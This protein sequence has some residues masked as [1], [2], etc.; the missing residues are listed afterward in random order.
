MEII[1]PTNCPSCSTELI[2]QNTQ[3]YCPNDECPAKN[4]KKVLNFAK[5]LKIKGLGPATQEKLSLTCIS[6]I[7]TIEESEVKSVLGEVLGSKL[8][9]QIEKSKSASLNELLPALGIPLIGDSA[10][11]KLCEAI[12]HFN[13]VNEET[14]KKAGLG[15]KAT[16]NLI[17][18]K[19]NFPWEELPFSFESE[20]VIKHE[21][22]TDIVCITGRLTSF[23]TKNDAKLALE[24]AGYK[25]VSSVTKDTTILVNES[26]IPSAKT[27]KAESSGVKVITNIKQLL[28]E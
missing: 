11:S 9:E 26:G 28:K 7:Y 20:E 18:Y 23:K 21:E 25:V 15:P 8:V 12:N 17:N 3:L 13:E 16:D 14:C 1:A 4:S 19:K 5:K 10:S 6:E 22:G 27:K 2:T 24:A